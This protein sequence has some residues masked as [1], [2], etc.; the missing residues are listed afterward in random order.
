MAV[1]SPFE[2]ATVLR[3][4]KNDF[5]GNSTTAYTRSHATAT[6]RAPSAPALTHGP[7]SRRRHRPPEPD[8]YEQPNRH[9]GIA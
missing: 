1:M 4:W 6:T 9:A 5:L 2:M 7:E 8:I 3:A